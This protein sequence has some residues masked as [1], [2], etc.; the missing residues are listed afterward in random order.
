MFQNSF[1]SFENMSCTLTPTEEVNSTKVSQIILDDIHDALIEHDLNRVVVFIKKKWYFVN[2]EN[3]TIRRVLEAIGY[4]KYVVTWVSRGEK[5][6]IHDELVVNAPTNTI[7]VF[8]NP[9]KYL[10]YDEYDNL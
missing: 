10:K 1:K 7:R 4:K 6:D 9:D 3:L 2:G 8:S 5:Y